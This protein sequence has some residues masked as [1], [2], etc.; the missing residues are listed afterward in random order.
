[1]RGSTGCK[2]VA[3][4]L[5]FCFSL[6][7][8]TLHLY[9]CRYVVGT[10]L[11]PL[12]PTVFTVSV[13]I[14]DNRL[15]NKRIA[16]SNSED[17]LVA[18]KVKVAFFDKTGT[19]TR[20][21]LDFISAQSA[22]MWRDEPSRSN[23][24]AEIALGMACC[25]GLSQSQNG[26]MVGNV[27]DRTMF[28]TT[29]AVISSVENS[30][31]S[32]T[33]KDGSLIRVLKNFDFDHERMTQSVI[34]LRSDGSL[35]VIVKGSG[36]SIQRICAPQ[37]L[38]GNFGH[39]TK[40]SAKLGVYQISMATKTLAPGVSLDSITRDQ[41]ECDLTFS[42][43]VN[44]QNVLR[45]DAPDVISQLH[46]G[47]I[48]TV[49]VTG[50]SLL[51]GITVARECGIF[52]PGAKVLLCETFSEGSPLKWTDGD[53]HEVVGALP[54]PEQL[55]S[56]VAG[57]AVTGD[58]WESLQERDIAMASELAPFIRVFGRCT[59][60][61]KVSVVSH[62]TGRG[63]ITLMCGDGGNDCGALKAAHVGVALSVAEAS[64]V[65]PFTSMDKSIGS[66]LEIIME[67]RCALAS[68]LASYKYIVMYGQVEAINNIFNAY[69][70]INLSEYCWMFMDGFWVISMSFTLPLAKAAKG[71]SETRPTS[72]L[73]GPIT[74]SS[75][76]GILLINLSFTSLA[77]ILLFRQDWFECRKWDNEDVSNLILIGDN[78][79]AE[80]I[81]LVSGYQYIS[82]AMAYNFGYE[83]R[84]SWH[85]NRWLVFFIALYSGL[86]FWVTLV[87]GKMSCFWR[88]NCENDNVLYSAS[89]GKVLPIQNPFHTTVMPVSF[90]FMLLFVMLANTAAIISWDYFVVNGIRRKLGAKRRSNEKRY[91][92]F[93]KATESDFETV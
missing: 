39:V 62:W 67:G 10:L 53:S 84:Q 71:L 2:L 49:M 5:R 28:A 80:T 87:P 37:S 59:P 30:T 31:V 48:Q 68:A 79:E 22:S 8:L 34:L 83:F 18:G 66:V 45:D 75:V 21:G 9:R 72:S 85:K 57:L 73:L 63:F 78:Y 92:G 23:V 35:F 4:C 17:I 58:V 11:P 33:T 19:L 56:G 51:A 91:T 52:G 20:Q 65:A 7:C 1:M 42:G 14:S 24:S 47:G 26:E 27:V 38:P 76:L 46:G 50:D 88:V 32:I 15:S 77:L 55:E 82:T 13:G 44:F 16:C 54:P 41:V 61:H 29:D 6:L 70:R 25:H 90:R 64:I 40:E 74:V 3:D 43:V 93:F 81:F 12:L 36:E 60:A 86:H 69:F 89:W